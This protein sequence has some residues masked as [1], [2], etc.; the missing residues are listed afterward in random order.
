MVVPQSPAAVRESPSCG[1]VGDGGITPLFAAGGGKEKTAEPHRGPCHY[2]PCHGALPED[3]SAGRKPPLS[4]GTLAKASLP[5]LHPLSPLVYPSS[6][7]P[8]LSPSPPLSLSSSLPLLSPLLVFLPPH[9][10][11]SSSFLLLLLPPHLLLLSRPS[12]CTRL[13]SMLTILG[14]SL[15]GSPSMAAGQRRLY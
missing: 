8:F 13:S 15:P 2:P 11:T 7:L 10:S 14:T 3:S 12:P 9:L 1:G 6:L 4:A 5:T